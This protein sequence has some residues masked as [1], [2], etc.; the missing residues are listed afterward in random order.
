MKRPNHSELSIARMPEIIK[1]LRIV[2]DPTRMRLLAL[3]FAHE[4]SVNELREITRLGQSR[5][6]THLAL[7]QESGLLEQRKDGKKNFYKL[8]PDLARN[9]SEGVALA[10]RGAQELN[11]YEADQINLKRVLELRDNKA[12]EYFNKAAGRFGRVYGPGR[13]W[14][15]F[16]NLLLRIV[17]AIDVA[18]LGAGEGIL[19]E[20]M[21][22]R[23]RKV[24][25]VDN[26][27]KIV[28]F[29]AQRATE[30]KLRNLEF[31]LGELESPPIDDESVDLA[32]L[33]Q[34]LHHTNTPARAIHSAFRILREGGQIIILDLV[35]HQFE[36]ARE[37]FGD[38]ILGFA[39]SDL[40][41][42][43]DDAGFKDI[44]I[45]I[46]AKEDQEPHFETVLAV[47]QKR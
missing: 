45:T 10:T 37:L 30:K 6:S 32:I 41:R 22:R 36:N 18:D 34:A 35:K 4:L 46:I 3:L 13:S 15:A 2:S 16:G 5:I 39:E 20:L 21:A 8:A 9:A 33:S 26:S 38:K 1:C 23:C 14:E 40:H 47:G 7:L 11:E 42:W 29:G 44:E 43:L 17:P 27:E 25:A 12:Q 19:S 28:A 31:R 24:I